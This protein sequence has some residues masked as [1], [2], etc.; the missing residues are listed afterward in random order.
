MLT[1]KVMIIGYNE[2]GKKLATYLEEEGTNNELVGFCEEVEKV[3]E[4]SNYP[5]IATISHSIEAAQK[6]QVQEIFSTIAP[7]Q[8]HGIYKLMQEADQACIHFRLIPD[9]SCFVKS[10]FYLDYLKDI[11]V[12]SLR[13]EPL[14]DTSNR[15]RKRAF[16]I[17]F[18]LF[19]L[20]F[21]FSWMLPLLAL[22][23]YLESP[24]PIF[25]KHLRTG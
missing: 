24:G 5:I 20:I 23:I 18:S 10:T 7:E 22:L 25:F 12:I 11:P 9:L 8:N 19:V 2:V 14:S 16:D 1:H 3:K 6:Y 13:N 21:F 4:L 17:V 15:V